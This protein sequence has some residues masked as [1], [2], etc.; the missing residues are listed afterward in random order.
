MRASLLATNVSLQMEG[1]VIGACECAI[2]VLTFERTCTG[3]L[4]IVSCE[5]VRSSETPFA[6]L[7]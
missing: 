3:V 4:P 5:L 6:A 2:T 7:P 1:E